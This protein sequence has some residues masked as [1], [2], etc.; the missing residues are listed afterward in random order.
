MII[1]SSSGLFANPKG[2]GPKNPPNA[3]FAL[4]FADIE[5]IINKM[6]EKININPNIICFSIVNNYFIFLK[7]FICFHKKTLE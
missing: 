7:K 3:N 6:P 4:A 2:I 5:F 1:F